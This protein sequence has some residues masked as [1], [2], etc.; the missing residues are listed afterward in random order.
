MKE[1]I[2]LLSGMIMLDLFTFDPISEI[3][4]LDL[5]I[6]YIG[7]FILAL[8]ITIPFVILFYKKIERKIPSPI[9]IILFVPIE[10]FIF[11]YLPI[12]LFNKDIAILAHF[13]WALCHVYIPSMI[14]VGIHGLL[15]LRLWLG[16]LWIE[17]VLIHLIHDLFFVILAK[18]LEGVGENK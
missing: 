10:D 12:T 17:A 7:Y 8:V 11:R 4:L 6:L 5:F 1:I 18:S 9:F 3:T 16:G 15:E 2:I 14:F 13:I